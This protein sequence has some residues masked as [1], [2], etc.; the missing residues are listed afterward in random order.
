MKPQHCW[1]DKSIDQRKNRFIQIPFRN[2]IQRGSQKPS[3]GRTIPTSKRWKRQST[4]AG[5]YSPASCM[6][7]PAYR[8]PRR[9]TR[10]QPGRQLMCM[11]NLRRPRSWTAK[12]S[13]RKCG[14]SVSKS[15]P[16]ID[17]D[18]LTLERCFK[19]KAANSECQAAQRV[20]HPTSCYSYD[21][22]DVLM[23]TV[24][25]D[26]SLLNLSQSKYMHTYH[27]GLTTHNW[28]DIPGGDVCM[29]RCDNIFMGRTLQ[30]MSVPLVHKC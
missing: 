22:G 11:S 24:P 23:R 19:E 14:N 10:R 4:V 30:M 2:T 5:L 17:A 3:P 29:A 13:H 12:C 8:P 26:G 18:A 28:Q 9:W 20:G 15:N 6:D 1:S 7:D 25:I 16:Y 27:T 21:A